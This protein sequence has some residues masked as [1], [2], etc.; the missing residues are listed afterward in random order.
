MIKREIVLEVNGVLYIVK[1]YEA[2]YLGD[3]WYLILYY[4]GLNQP[5]KLFAKEFEQ[6][7]VLYLVEKV[8]HA[9]D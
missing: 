2:K 9:D 5:L 1:D 7:T 6:K 3:K 4:E 8:N